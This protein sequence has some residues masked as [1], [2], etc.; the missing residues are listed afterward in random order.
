LGQALTRFDAYQLAKY[1]REN[2][3]LNLVDA[4]N[5]LHPPHTEALSQLVAGTLKPADTWETKLTQAGQG[6]GDEVDKWI[7]KSEAWAEL[8]RSRKIGYFALLRNLRNILEDSPEVLDE[9]VALL[10]DKRR[11]EKSLVMPFR[12]QTA[13]D[14]IRDSHLLPRRQE[15]IR[16]LGVAVDHSLVN[17]PRFDGRT[18]IALDGSGSMAERPMKIGSL[19]ASVLYRVNDADLLIFSDEAEFVTFNKDDSTLTI[20][21]QLAAHAKCA[22]T[23]FHAVFN[24][25]VL[26]Y[27]RVILLSDMQAWMGGNV[28]TASFEAYVKRA[29]LR[30]KIYS[31]DLAGY[32]IA[33]ISRSWRLCAGGVF[34]QDDGNTAFS[35]TRPKRIAPSD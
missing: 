25:A 35:G 20:A 13:L 5:L 2:A 21:Q 19:F 10:Q 31:F 7:R 29:H 14:A 27:D 1:R 18:L 33:S 30:P 6:G 17:V 32:R 15:V 23:N 34:R 12:F 16:A 9:A 11:I 3:E 26:P 4:V 24:R 28:P 22:G 8:V